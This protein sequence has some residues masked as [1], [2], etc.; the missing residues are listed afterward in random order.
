MTFFAVSNELENLDVPSYLLVVPSDGMSVLTAWSAQTFTPD[1]V[2]QT[3]EKFE[4]AKNINT[5]KIIIPGLLSDMCEELHEYCPD[6]EFIEGTKEASDIED[7]V[8][9]LF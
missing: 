4:I 6:F 5:R 3:L 2:K 8:K 1:V 7:F 9:G